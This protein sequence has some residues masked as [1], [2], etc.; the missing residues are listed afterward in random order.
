MSN[1]SERIILHKASSVSA[2]FSRLIIATTGSSGSAKIG[3][4]D[5]KCRPVSGPVLGDLTLSFVERFP[6]AIPSR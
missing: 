1:C 3:N 5:F 4:G 6:C 2:S